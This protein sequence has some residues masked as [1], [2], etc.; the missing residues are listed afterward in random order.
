M[1]DYS[2]RVSWHLS[3]AV[4]GAGGVS[5]GRGN[6]H[7]PRPCA[8]PGPMLA[9]CDD[10]VIVVLAVRL[11]AGRCYR[12]RGRISWWVQACQVQGGSWLC[13]NHIG[14]LCHCGLRQ[15]EGQEQVLPYKPQHTTSAPR[16][17]IHA[18]KSCAVYPRPHRRR[19]T[20]R[21]L[22][23]PIFDL[24]LSH[25]GLTH[26]G[27]NGTQPLCVTHG[28]TP[29]VSSRWWGSSV[30]GHT[31]GGAGDEDGRR[32]QGDER[33]WSFSAVYKSCRK[34]CRKSSN[35]PEE[36]VPWGGK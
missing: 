3:G 29:L 1:A 30:R 10:N 25:H 11:E 20:T 13:T 17:I 27:S 35:R 9:Q 5:T 6:C 7:P 19:G 36:L 33:N 24:N 15:S 23:G 26:K 8:G 18:T 28:G 21:K 22:V 4:S 12:R 14:R 34:S 2:T 32:R 31:Y 16:P